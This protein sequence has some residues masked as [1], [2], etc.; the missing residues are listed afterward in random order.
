LKIEDPEHISV[1]QYIW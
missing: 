1:C